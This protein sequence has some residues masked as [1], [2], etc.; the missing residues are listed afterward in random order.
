MEHVV[1]PGGIKRAMYIYAIDVYLAGV[2][3][4]LRDPEKV[5]TF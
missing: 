1:K 4:T 2:I 3:V 5:L